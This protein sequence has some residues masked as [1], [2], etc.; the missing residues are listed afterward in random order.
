MHQRPTQPGETAGA[1]GRD[2]LCVLHLY[3]EDNRS[4]LGQED[5]QSASQQLFPSLVSRSAPGK[6]QYGSKKKN[7]L[8]CIKTKH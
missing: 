2:P 8:F 4:G 1:P 3:G 7:P 6:W 5:W